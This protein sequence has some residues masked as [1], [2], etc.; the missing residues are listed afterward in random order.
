MQFIQSSTELTTVRAQAWKAFASERL[1]VIGVVIVLI[2]GFFA[3]FAPWVS[4]SDPLAGIGGDRLL[5]PLSPGYLLGTD[6]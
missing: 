1:A 6:G 4:P 2:A 5:P 3:I